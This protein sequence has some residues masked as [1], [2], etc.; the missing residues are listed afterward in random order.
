M[1]PINCDDLGGWIPL[2][3]TYR[4][5]A[6]VAEACESTVASLVRHGLL[7]KEEADDAAYELARYADYLEDGYQLAKKLEDRAH[8]DP[9]AQMVEVLGGHASSWVGALIRQVQEWVRL[10][11]IWPPFSVGT[12]VAVPWRRRVE[13]GTIARIFPE[14]GECAVR[15]DIETR[16]DCYAA[17]AYEA[18]DLLA[19][20]QVSISA[21]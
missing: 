13:P 15:L 21:S 6:V 20:D 12:R 18:I 5:P 1:R 2:R 11:E 17:V 4:D 9:S 14:S 10:Y 19:T 7:Q 3:P 8:W 16:S